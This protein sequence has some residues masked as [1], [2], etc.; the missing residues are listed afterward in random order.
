MSTW[1]QYGQTLQGAGSGDLLGWSLDMD[2]NGE[3]LIVGSPAEGENDYGLATVYEFNGTN[4]VQKGD[5]I[6]GTSTD[7]GLGWSVKIDTNLSNQ[8]VVAISS[9]NSLR[10]DA[11][12]VTPRVYIYEWDGSAW[13]QKG[14]TIV[15]PLQTNDS[16]FGFS[17]DLSDNGNLISIGSPNVD[18]V[19][20]YSYNDINLD[21]NQ[22]GLHIEPQDFNVGGQFGYSVAL[23][24]NAS[25]GPI[26]VIGEPEYND[27]TSSAPGINGRV[28]FYSFEPG[29]GDWFQDGIISGNY[30]DS[31]LGA[32]VIISNSGNLAFATDSGTDGG[33]PATGIYTYNY[34]D[35]KTP[36]NQWQLKSLI[37]NPGQSNYNDLFGRSMRFISNNDVRY[38][39]GDILVASQS[40]I[41]RVYGFEYND[42]YGDLWQPYGSTLQG[43]SGRLFGNSI[44]TDSNLSLM[45]VGAPFTNDGDKLLNGSVQVFQNQLQP[46]PCF[47]E[48]AIVLTD[49][50]L[51]P[52]ENITVG[53]YSIRRM[54]IVHVS[55]LVSKNVDGTDYLV[56]F[57]QD[58]L[59]EGCPNKETVCSP[60]HMVFYNGANI[61][62]EKLL[63][64][65]VA[66]IH[67]QEYNEEKLYN[68]QLKEYSHMFV[69]GMRT[70]TLHPRNIWA[71]KILGK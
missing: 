28:S 31:G 42:S 48:G 55:T 59:E 18:R 25:R 33:A 36:P 49:Q 67:R 46:I 41:G 68:I 5:K 64:K 56:R 51:I 19:Y 62:A 66:G 17:I 7:Q 21:W 58:A 23:T 30:N 22:K 52:I 40:F 26:L 57:E 12:D 60:L 24:T 71:K 37:A 32:N 69:N 43:P 8:P 13:D 11:N 4:W 65:G 20:V 16:L 9:P 63:Q 38:V 2:Q 14:Q 50:G 61:T 70:E 1:S 15:D 45:A 54:P 39:N 27:T 44:G 47:T 35:E 3:T 53:K 29:V 10:D 6:Q 34:N